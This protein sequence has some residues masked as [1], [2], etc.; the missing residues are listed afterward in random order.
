MKALEILRFV[1][2]LPIHSLCRRRVAFH[3]VYFPSSRASSRWDDF[4][5][6]FIYSWHAD[7]AWHF[8]IHVSH[9]PI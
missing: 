6:L 8:F 4:Y 7:E 5:T 1:V 3:I 2:S 9:L